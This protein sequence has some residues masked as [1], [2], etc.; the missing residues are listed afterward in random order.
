MQGLFLGDPLGRWVIC[1][2]STGGRSR[3][4]RIDSVWRPW[5]TWSGTADMHRQ[6]PGDRQYS[7]V[8]SIGVRLS[9]SHSFLASSA[10]IAYIVIES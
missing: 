5:P 3:L 8:L 7:F 2:P 10:H 4:L 6:P 9:P 1:D